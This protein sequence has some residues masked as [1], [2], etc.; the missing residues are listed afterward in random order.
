[1]DE[2][3]AEGEGEGE[4]EMEAEAVEA[5]DRRGQLTRRCRKITTFTKSTTMNW[6]LSATKNEATSGLP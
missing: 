1:M 6:V 2:A 4:V 3:E 5:S